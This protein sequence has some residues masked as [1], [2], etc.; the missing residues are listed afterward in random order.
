MITT[1]CDKT[2]ENGFVDTVREGGERRNEKVA[3]TY[4][5]YHV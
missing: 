1:Y 5:H 2:I 3:L 4:T